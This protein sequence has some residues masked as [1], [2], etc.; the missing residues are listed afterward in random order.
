MNTY[1][2]K[3]QPGL[4][5]DYL[6][7]EASEPIIYDVFNSEEKAKEIVKKFPFM[8]YDENL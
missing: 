2:V 7:P 5:R 6:Y 4:A 8:Y 3:Y 1:T